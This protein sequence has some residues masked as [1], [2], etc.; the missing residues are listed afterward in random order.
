VTKNLRVTALCGRFLAERSTVLRKRTLV[1]YEEQ[2]RIRVVPWLG[3]R[4]ANDVSH[5]LAHETHR[6]WRREFGPSAANKSKRWAS[7]AWRWGARSDLI[8]P[9]NPW[10]ALPNWEEEC[11]RNPIDRDQAAVVRAYL[12]S[13][14]AGHTGVV[15]PAY[16]GAFLV[17]LS[18]GL[19]ISNVL[20]LRRTELVDGE[21]VIPRH[22]GRG[23]LR[24]ALNRYARELLERLPVTHE[25]WFFPNPRS[26]SGRIVEYSRPW[27]RVR[28]K[29]EIGRVTLH[30][31]RRGFAMAAWEAGCDSKDVQLLLGHASA[32]TTQTYYLGY[33]R[34]RVSR[35]SEA[36]AVALGLQCELFDGGAA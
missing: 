19:R 4:M 7:T 2:A 13:I 18:T 34:Q 9:A 11:R 36:T 32:S 25:V 17:A 20:H 16:A 29:L 6:E 35:S 1:S 15:E 31:L 10:H 3:D 21:L 23:V 30:D 24:V 26:A 5:G 27:A 12:E 28:E 14:L 8:E 33:S 22:K